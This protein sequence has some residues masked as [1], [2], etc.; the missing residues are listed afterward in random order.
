M[1]RVPATR[2]EEER[3]TRLL[4]ER[5]VLV[6]P[7]FFFDFPHEAYLV[8]SLLPAKAE[9]AEGVAR[10][11]ADQGSVTLATARR[12]LQLMREPS[13]KITPA[14]IHARITWI[15]RSSPIDRR[16]ENRHRSA[17]VSNP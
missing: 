10:L 3:V 7:G 1:L 6:H 4:E 5:D 15:M 16:H 12:A 9:F 8:P 14:R 2:T 11:I 13:G 17:G